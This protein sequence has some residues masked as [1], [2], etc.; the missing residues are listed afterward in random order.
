MADYA[1]PGLRAALERASR[2][3]KAYQRAADDE[4]ERIYGKP[5]RAGRGRRGRRQRASYGR[6]VIDAQERRE[7]RRDTDEE[8]AKKGLE[9]FKGAGRVIEAAKSEAG[10]KAI[11]ALRA[12]PL[13]SGAAIGL[14][15]TAG[16]AA[17]GLTSYVIRKMQ[18]KKEG[19]EQLAFQASQA[20]RAAR[21]QL[22]ERQGQPLSKAQQVQL[23]NGFKSELKK[24][25]LTTTNLF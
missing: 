9:I 1:I 2:Q 25:G 11:G 21:V 13:L 4:T 6:S 17:Y 20:Y 7:F 10:K 19:R 22:E 8:T 16:L 18:E 23:A 14:A 12:V 15:I 24:L 5:R 3:G